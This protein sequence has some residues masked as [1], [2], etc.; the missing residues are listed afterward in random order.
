MEKNK[1]HDDHTHETNQ[2]RTV[3]VLLHKSSG[4]DIPFLEYAEAVERAG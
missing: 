3:A 2:K 1:K 4:C